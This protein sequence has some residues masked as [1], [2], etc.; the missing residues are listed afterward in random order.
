MLI[1][2]RVLST[3]A[4]LAIAMWMGGLVAL[5]AVAAPVVFGVVPFPANADAMTIVFRRFDAVAM[6]CAAIVLA[7]EAIRPVVG[8]GF[9]RLTPARTAATLVAALAAVYEGIEVSPRIAE[10]HAGGAIRGMDAAGVEL[11]RLHDL[12]E[13][14]GKIELLLLVVVVALH[15]VVLSSGAREPATRRAPV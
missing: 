4:L 1:L 12:A 3:V 9:E 10:L 5:G 15:V 13:W 14:C 8:L 11:A 6:T 2:R 7:T